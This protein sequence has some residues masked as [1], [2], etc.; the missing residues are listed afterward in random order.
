MAEEQAPIP[1]AVTPKKKFPATLILIII[2][3]L[4]G[5]AVIFLLQSGRL[6][7]KTPPT[8][9]PTVQV[10]PTPEIIPTLAITPTPLTTPTTTVDDD[11]KLIKQAILN[12]LGLT[13]S[14]AVVTISQNTGQYAKGGV[15]EI[16]AVGGGYFLAAKV[17]GNWVTVYDGQANPTC[18]QLAPYN[19]PTDMVPEC[20]DSSGKVVKR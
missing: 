16:E 9:T 3:V 19:F 1:Y 14:Q 8:T 2:I 18:V 13:E 4:L 7:Q 20:L 11:N 10:T 15:K 5:F 12:K 17:G 6:S